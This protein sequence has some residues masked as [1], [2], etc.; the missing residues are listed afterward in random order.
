MLGEYLEYGDLFE[1]HPLSSV[2]PSQPGWQP[3][4]GNAMSPLIRLVFPVAGLWN[5]STGND[6]GRSERPAVFSRLPE[7]SRIREAAPP[8]L[9][10][11]LAIETHVFQRR[12]EKHHCV[13]EVLNTTSN[14]KSGAQS[15]WEWAELPRTKPASPRVAAW[16]G[17]G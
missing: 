7:K 14:P 4:L 12:I 6:A 9:P 3:K 17:P 5:S 16:N 13:A 2:L 15:P 11:W 10:G 1:G 8:S